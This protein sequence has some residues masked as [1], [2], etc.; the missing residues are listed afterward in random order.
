MKRSFSAAVISLFL[1][2]GGVILWAE[3]NFDNPTSHTQTPV[4]YWRVSDIKKLFDGQQKEF[5]FIRNKNLADGGGRGH[6]L[7][8]KW[9]ISDVHE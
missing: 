4:G 2:T 7:P 9:N 3:N 5:W 6:R 8:R 1:I